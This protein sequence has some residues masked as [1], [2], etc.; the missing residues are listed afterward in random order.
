MHPE[1]DGPALELDHELSE[2]YAQDTVG[3]G[4]RV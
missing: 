3:L 2:M 4:S 1:N